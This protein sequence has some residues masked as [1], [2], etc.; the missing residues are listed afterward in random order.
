MNLIEHASKYALL[1][2]LVTLTYNH[3]VDC[4]PIITSVDVWLHLL[5]VE[6]INGEILTYIYVSICVVD[7]IL[8][9]CMDMDL[10]VLNN[11]PLL[12]MLILTMELEYVYNYAHLEM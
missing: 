8:L 2:I 4:L 11:V 9:V 6:L 12:I 10:I 3:W 1:T 7:L 5:L